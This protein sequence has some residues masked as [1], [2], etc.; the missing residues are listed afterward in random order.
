ML[1]ERQCSRTEAISSKA[2]LWWFIR[3]AE[4]GMSAATCWRR[5]ASVSIVEVGRF[6]LRYFTI[7]IKELAEWYG[8]EVARIAVDEMFD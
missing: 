3:L 4:S 1:M 8:L 5:D 6:E 2:K 7:E